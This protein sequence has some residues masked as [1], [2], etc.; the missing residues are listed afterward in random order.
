MKKVQKEYV[1]KL[2]NIVRQIIAPLKDC[3]PELPLELFSDEKETSSR[4]NNIQRKK[5]IRKLKKRQ[6]Q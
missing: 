1:E 3:P 5:V 2:E 6:K 4:K